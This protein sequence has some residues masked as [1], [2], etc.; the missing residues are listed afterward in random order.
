VD[1]LAGNQ[2]AVITGDFNSTDT[3][4]PYQAITA[5]G[6][7]DARTI[8]STRPAGPDYTFTGFDVTGKPG[9]RIDFI[10]LKNMKP[11]R[12]YVV[13]DDSSNGFYL[14]DHLPV[15]VTF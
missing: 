6:F 15:I 11:V 9:D 8:T 10:F 7:K 3:D 4:P 5:A 12:S 14:S 2:P 13:R 1:S